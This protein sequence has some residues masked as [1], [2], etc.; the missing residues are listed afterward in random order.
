[1]FRTCLIFIGLFTFY[2]SKCYGAEEGMPQLNP[3]FWVSQI[4]WLFLIFGSL[5][6]I[7]WK[8]ILPKISENLENRKVQILSD[9]ESAQKSKDES[10]KKITEYNK[11]LDQ[12]KNE[13]KNIL[14]EARK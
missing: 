4:F 12:A 11:I 6:L 5:Y 8:V 3:D 14:N 10:E 9:L 13:A 7:L 2:W 1:M